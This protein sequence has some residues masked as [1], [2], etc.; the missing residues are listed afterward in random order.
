MSLWL[1]LNS[2]R[3]HKAGLVVVV[4]RRDHGRGIMAVCVVKTQTS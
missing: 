3:C 2:Q 1:V 4:M